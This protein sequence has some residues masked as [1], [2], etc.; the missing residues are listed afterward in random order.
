[1]VLN[2]YHDVFTGLGRLKV[3]PVKIHLREDAVPVR[4]PCRHVPVAIRK[5]FE[6]ELASSVKMFSLS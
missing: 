3:E 4:R 5:Q 1:M 6:D 2:L